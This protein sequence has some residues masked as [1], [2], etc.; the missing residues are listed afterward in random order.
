MIKL[1]LILILPLFLNASKIL[2]YN[3]YD[4]TDRADVMITFDTPYNGKIRQSSSNSK[5]II[6][7]DDAFIESSK[8]KK[9]SSSYLSSITI[10]PMTTL[11]QIVATVPDNI[12]L[13]ASKT[14]DAYGL[15]LRFIKKTTSKID[16]EK[17]ASKSPSLSSLPTK[18][19][20]NISSSYYIVITVLILG[21]I[22][23]FVVNKK[24]ALKMGDKK[25]NPWLFKENNKTESNNEKELTNE[26]GNNVSIK[27]Q[28]NLNS[29][30]SVVMLEFGN[31]SY[32][33]LM[34]NS[35]ILLDKFTDNK[36]S[37]QS[38]FDIILQ[39]R[40]EELENY[41]NVAK[42][43]ENIKAKESLQNYK[44]K[45]AIISYQD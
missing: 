45:A 41:F 24:I 6:K 37:T 21:I 1:L 33:V 7:L 32:L 8:I 35:N 17:I 16:K 39:D 12:K 19:N 42:N 30:N 20:E 22:I 44:E 34:G 36:P 28:K 3:I 29:D 23:L 4:R 11:T 25:T 2:S 27:F 31:Q 43:D 26:K 14:A 40:H 13:K 15:R 5:I 9:L 18:K 10:T 38:D